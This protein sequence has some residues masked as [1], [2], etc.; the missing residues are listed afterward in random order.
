MR[1]ASDKRRR[2]L[3]SMRAQLLQGTLGLHS[4]YKEFF[5]LMAKEC[6]FTALM[7]VPAS[8]KMME[9]LGVDVARSTTDEVR[10]AC[11]TLGVKVVLHKL[12][13]KPDLNGR[14]GIVVSR[15]NRVGVLLDQAIQPIAVKPS[16][17]CIMTK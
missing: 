16:N 5:P 2:I 8:M 4:L 9:L 7:G 14:K 17:L 1:L 3:F 6:L 12:R 11:Y 13:A 10:A 15:F